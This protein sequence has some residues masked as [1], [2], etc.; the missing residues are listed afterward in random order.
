M[1]PNA[2]TT[3]S[4]TVRR[5]EH[6]GKIAAIVEAQMHGGVGKAEIGVAEQH[7]LAFMRQRMREGHGDQRLAGA[8]FARTDGEE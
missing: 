4:A 6:A 3:A 5:R 1:P 2:G 7:L 8:A